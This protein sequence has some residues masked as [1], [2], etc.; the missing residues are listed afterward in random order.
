MIGSSYLSDRRSFFA[1]ILCTSALFFGIL[2]PF[3]PP[4]RKNLLLAEPKYRKDFGVRSSA[5]R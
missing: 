1:D 4:F 2:V 3:A 5:R